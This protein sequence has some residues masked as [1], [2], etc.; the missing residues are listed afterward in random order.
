MFQFLS[1]KVEQPFGYF[2]M[3]SD[4]DAWRN[5]KAILRP[6]EIIILTSP[7]TN[8]LLSQPQTS[9]PQCL[10]ILLYLICNLYTIRAEIL[11]A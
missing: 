6:E 10:V 3:R 11:E 5:L 8:Q 7:L 9:K 1:T 4:R 2:P